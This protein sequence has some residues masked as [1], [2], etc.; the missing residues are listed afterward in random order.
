MEG[1]L[2]WSSF[3]SHGKTNSWGVQTASL[4]TEKIIVKNQQTNQEGLI[5][6]LHVS[7]NDC[8][9]ILID[10]GLYLGQITS[11]KRVGAQNQKHPNR[12]K[13]NFWITK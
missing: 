2:S 5:L 6:I 8:K 9:Y 3:F 1:R 7:I 4:E 13:K 12:D 11:R 10:T